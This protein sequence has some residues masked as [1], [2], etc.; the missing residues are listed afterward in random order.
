MQQDGYTHGIL[1]PESLVT[2]KIRPCIISYRPSP[3]Q[4]AYHQHNPSQVATKW[5]S[6]ELAN[7]R[8]LVQRPAR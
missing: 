6:G 4:N 8:V 5:R 2:Q 3:T 7:V 1:A